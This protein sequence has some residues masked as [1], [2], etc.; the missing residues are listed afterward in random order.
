MDDRMRALS[1]AFREVPLRC[2]ELTLRPLTSGSV[3]ILMALGNPLFADGE[4]EREMG[5]QEIFEYIWVHT[6]PLDEV[7]AGAD[8]PTYVR[9]R[10]RALGL[11]ISIEDLADFAQQFLQLMERVKATMVEEVIDEPRGKSVG[12]PQSPTGLPRWSGPWEGQE[13]Q[14]GNGGSFGSS[15][16]TGPCNISTLPS[17][18]T[19]AS[20]AG[21]GED[22]EADPERLPANVI[23]LPSLPPP[24]TAG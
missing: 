8:D 23:P 3:E 13:T 21:D 11:E 1:R 16:S 12:A 10:A 20:A 17:A 2:G 6:A 4:G 15:P 14:P 9:Q 5:Y 24:G 19:D 18:T 7:A 22:G